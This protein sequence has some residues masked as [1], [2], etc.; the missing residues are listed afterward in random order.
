MIN[1]KP[2]L[3]SVLNDV[4]EK[5]VDEITTGAI[6]A[7]R[8]K[9]LIEQ[10][11]EDFRKIY[12]SNDSVRVFSKD[13]YDNRAEFGMNEL[14]H[15]ILVCTTGLSSAARHKKKLRYITSAIWQVES[16][17]K[18]DTHAALIDFNKLVLGSATN[19]LFIGPL[20]TYKEKVL[21]TLLPAALA[22]QRNGANVHIAFVTHPKDWSKKP[23]EVH[24]WALD[25][26]KW[27][28]L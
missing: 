2:F 7:K 3:L 17:L 21:Q 1:L 8:S 18:N 5:P 9:N 4:S 20:F 27:I 16:E 26:D 19:K 11:S 10:L 12:T 6:N 24:A 14:L 13:H 15:D 23:L 28:E 22:A 25:I